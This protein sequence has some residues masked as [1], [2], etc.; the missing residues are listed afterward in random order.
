MASDH[1]P[2]EGAMEASWLGCTP[3]RHSPH[4]SASL[5]VTESNQSLCMAQCVE[6]RGTFAGSTVLKMGQVF[7]TEL[8]KHAFQTKKHP[9]QHT[10]KCS[11]VCFDP[12]ER[13]STKG[14]LFP[15]TWRLRFQVKGLCSEL[16]DPFHSFFE[17]SLIPS[18]EN[19]DAPRKRTFKDLSDAAEAK[20]VTSCR[21]GT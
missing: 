11:P 13:H 8:S 4:L 19:I 9:A 2:L 21:L 3:P 5:E 7:K 20:V 10:T 17:L 1:R 18:V 15:S 16:A 12:V 6:C 14:L